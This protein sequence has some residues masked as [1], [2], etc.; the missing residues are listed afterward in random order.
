VQLQSQAV[1]VGG[2]FQGLEQSPA[3]VAMTPYFLQLNVAADGS[4][5]SPTTRSALVRRVAVEEVGGFNEQLI[6][7]EDYDLFLRLRRANYS[8]AFAKQALVYWRGPTRFGEFIGKLA[9]FA[10]SDIEAGLWRPKVTLLFARYAVGV[11]LLFSPVPWLLAILLSLYLTWSIHKHRAYLPKQWWWLPLL[12]VSADLAV[13]GGT[14][15][16]LS[17]FKTRVV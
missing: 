9:A 12:Q 10:S 7:S 6:L 17:R 5:F 13:M 4:N 15:R 8:F 3:A 14:L 16:A 2:F 1:A 11:L